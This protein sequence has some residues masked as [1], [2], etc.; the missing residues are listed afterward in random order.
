MRRASLFRTA[1]FRLA[2]LYLALFSASTVALGAFVYWSIRHEILA[3]FDEGIAEERDALEH[4]F[5]RQG[6]ERLIAVLNARA[7]RGESASAGLWGPDGERLGGD[8]TLAPAALP[9]DGGWFDAPETDADEASESEPESLRGLA[10]RLSDGSLLVVAEEQRRSNEALK[11]IMVAFGWALA[12][13]LALGA[14]GGLWLSA[15]FLQRIHAMRQAAQGIMAGDWSRRIPLSSVDDD[16]TALARTFN[17][18]FERI[19]RL[20]L[21]NKHVSA[22]IAHDLRK[23]LAR[24]LR[25]LE[26]ARATEAGDAS[27]AEAIAGATTEVEGVLET[28]DALLR[29]GQIEAGARRAGFRSVDLAEIARD[30]VDAFRPTAEEQGRSLV[31]RLDAPL[32]MSGDRELLT[33]MIANCLDNALTH[34]PPGAGVEVEGRVG[35]YGV[36][37]SVADGGPGVAAR[38]LARL[39]EPFFRGDES[40]GSLGSGLGLSL[41]AA[42]ADLHGLSCSASDNRPGLR[43]A[44]AAA[45]ARD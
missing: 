8:L 36:M 1:S 7:A 35:P 26:A 16:L 15:Q 28:F 11:R 21:A 18:L 6:R 30:V 5:L 37:L 24:V 34:T 19:E 44:F 4:V 17:R 29:I 43:I 41:A 22:D 38:D 12:G 45:A 10:T 42:I 31:V 40:R 13:T 32:P 39:F 25:R 3:E 14:A 2:A 27:A 23:P 20:L 9:H 33:Q